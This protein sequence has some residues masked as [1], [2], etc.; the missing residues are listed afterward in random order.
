MEIVPGRFQTFKALLRYGRIGFSPPSC[1]IFFNVHWHLQS[2]AGNIQGITKEEWRYSLIK[3]PEC[4]LERLTC[5][6]TVCCGP[7]S[8]SYYKEI[9][10]HNVHFPESLIKSL[11]AEFNHIYVLMRWQRNEV[12]RIPRFLDSDGFSVISSLCFLSLNIILIWMCDTSYW[13]SSY[14]FPVHSIL[15]LPLFDPYWKFVGPITW[16]YQALLTVE[17][18][19]PRWQKN[20]GHL[21]GQ[22]SW[23]VKGDGIYLF[24]FLWEIFFL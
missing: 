23:R 14:F 9:S 3:L 7:C 2:C 6:L 17:I 18:Q 5:Q 12:V 10:H 1:C 19:S 16:I 8:Y 20:W 21:E 24:P 11:L 13:L 15:Y 4:R 22:I